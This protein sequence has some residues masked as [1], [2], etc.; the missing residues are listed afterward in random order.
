MD[1]ELAVCDEMNP[2]NS[3]FFVRIFFLQIALKDICHAKIH[4]YD[5]FLPM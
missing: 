3:E 4:D 5:I 1:F 2:V